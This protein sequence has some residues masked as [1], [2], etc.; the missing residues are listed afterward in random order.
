V[1]K[2]IGWLG[3]GALFPAPLLA[4]PAREPRTFRRWH[5]EP[6]ARITLEAA[7]LVES[8][9]AGGRVVASLPFDS[10]TRVLRVVQGDALFP[11]NDLWLQ[12]RGGYLYATDAQPVSFHLPALPQPDLGA[13]RWAEVIVPFTE[14][15][16]TPGDYSPRS[17]AG[18][19]YYRSVF[20]VRELVEGADGKTWYRIE[21]EIY[22]PSYIRASHLSLFPPEMLSP[23]AAGIPPAARHLEVSLSEQIIR[24]FENGLPVWEQ[25]MS[26]GAPVPS[27][28]TPPGEY[29]I[30]EKRPGARLLDLTLED[31]PD[32][33]NIA[34]VPFVCYFAPNR[35]ATHGVY[36]H[37][38]F[39]RPVSQG[40]IN[41]PPDAAHWLWRW[42]TPLPDPYALVTLASE[43]SPGTRVV[44]FE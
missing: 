16:Y 21:D 19:V 2:S 5:G 10:I 44:V 35:V 37:N 15:L 40:C 32:M 28:Q 38:D 14:A 31:D 23:L 1:L 8:P 42:T 24:A 11:H 4:A 7:P 33:Y 6:L 20:F 29:A 3:L 26:S 17:R 27:Y 25:V 39:G 9:R 34:G 13:G 30:Y 41:L 18:R 43:A 12:T 22:S 36:W